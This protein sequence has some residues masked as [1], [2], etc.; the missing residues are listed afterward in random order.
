MRS[1][2][3]VPACTWHQRS[4]SLLCVPPSVLGSQPHFCPNQPERVR[5]TG[6]EGG[7]PLSASQQA[8]G[9]QA[10]LGSQE[11]WR[12][13]RHQAKGSRKVGPLFL[14]GPP[15]RKGASFLVPTLK[16]GLSLG[17]GWGLVP[18]TLAYFQVK[19]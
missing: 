1:K 8:P 13:G 10:A 12:P 6:R 9:Y 7:Q 4:P 18:A 14:P 11:K 19:N 2:L 17:R 5:S 16:R 15:S 3:T